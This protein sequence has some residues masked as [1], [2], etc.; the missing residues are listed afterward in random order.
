MAV[1][2]HVADMITAKTTGGGSAMDESDKVPGSP[3]HNPRRAPPSRAALI[4]NRIMAAFL[5]LLVVA[6]IYM[7]V[8]KVAGELWGVLRASPS[9]SF[10]QPSKLVDLA[11][12]VK[13]VADGQLIAVT[14]LIVVI[15]V[16]LQTFC[17]PGTIGLNVITGA[18]LGLGYG[19]PLCVLLG[20]LGASM[21]YT[22]SS[23]A[24]VRFAAAVDQKL[25]QGQGIGKLRSSVARYRADL[26]AYL[27]F[28]RLTPILPNWL[29]NLGSP[30]AN[31]PLKHFALAT[32]LGITPQTYLS[33]R[34]GTLAQT[35]TIKSIVT[36]Y[37]TLAV[38]A[39]GCVVLLVV[40]LKKKFAA[41]A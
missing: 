33:V 18:L 16:T 37:D 36:W 19:L 23:V 35:G 29:I 6:L 10:T 21:C 40:R 24:G 3:S 14:L 12:A 5:T 22:L 1:A 2:V 28:L 20:T 15:Y 27:L 8:H 4:R 39:I 13:K 17:I 38:A 31:V 25:M 26:F 34:F 41:P 32:M 11:A 7:E 9:G 30:L